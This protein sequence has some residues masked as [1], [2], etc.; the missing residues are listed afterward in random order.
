MNLTHTHKSSIPNHK[1]ITKIT[2][3]TIARMMGGGGQKKSKAQMMID[4]AKADV[5]LQMA[6]NTQKIGQF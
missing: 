1:T 5:E 3:I 6:P 4:A 2:I